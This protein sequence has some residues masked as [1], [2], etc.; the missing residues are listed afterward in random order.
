MILFGRFLNVSRY[1][2]TATVLSCLWVDAQATGQSHTGFDLTY[3][4]HAKGL[5]VGRTEVQLRPIRAGVFNYTSKS[6]AVGLAA[7]IRDVRIVEQSQFEVRQGKLKPLRYSYDRE[8]KHKRRSVRVDFDWGNGLASNTAKDRTWKIAIQPQ[9]LDKLN[10]ILALMADLVTGRKSFRYSIA[11]G[12]KLKV[13]TIQRLG[14]EKITT[15]LGPTETIVIQRSRKGGKRITT[16]WC[17]PAL[18]Y[19]PIQIRHQETNGEVIRLKLTSYKGQ[20]QSPALAGAHT[21]P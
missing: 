16:L 13:F 2:C 10:Y 7:L 18:G 19:A 1:A 4:L 20:V 15:L 11:D 21:L 5:I 6:A 14:T 17:A 3:D 12:G 8:G 9:T